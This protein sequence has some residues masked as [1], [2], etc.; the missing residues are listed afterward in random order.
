MLTGSRI[1]VIQIFPHAGVAVDKLLMSSFV[2][3]GT[4]G[5]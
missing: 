1:T 5:F 2:T 4:A 3:G